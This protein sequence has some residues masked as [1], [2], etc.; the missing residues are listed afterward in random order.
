MNICSIDECPR[1]SYVRSLCNGHY[2]RLMRYGDPLAGRRM[3]SLETDPYLK[4]MERV[5][6]ATDADGCWE[7]SGAKGYEGHGTLKTNG[8]ITY[9]HRIVYEHFNGVLEG[10][11]VV[12][13]RC[14]N[15]PCVRPEHLLQGT[16][17]DNMR[18]RDTRG[19]TPQGV[20]HCRAKLSIEQVQG[21]RRDRAQGMKL[22]DI[23]GRYGVSVAT[24]G[25]ASRRETYRDVE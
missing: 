2:K 16:Q 17:G 15:P 23:A 25:A 6:K 13:H 11:T 22:K 1:E 4:V 8:V 9:V 12:R 7:W 20:Q 18:D 5:V 24:A 10:S 14:D 19:R 3:R 21:I